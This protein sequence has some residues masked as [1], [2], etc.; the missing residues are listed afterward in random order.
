MVKDS[1]ESAKYDVKNVKMFLDF[2]HGS[3]S[4]LRKNSNPDKRTWIR[5]IELFLHVLSPSLAVCFPP[6]TKCEPGA[7]PT[8]FGRS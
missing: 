3:G 1:V 7:N 4:G 6:T 2:F 8:M 5:N